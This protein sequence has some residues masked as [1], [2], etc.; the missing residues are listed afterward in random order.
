MENLNLANP[1]MMDIAVPANVK[2]LTFRSNLEVV[3]KIIIIIYLIWLVII[4]NV[5]AKIVLMT[6]VLA[7]LK[8]LRLQTRVKMLL[9]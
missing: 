6:N 9:L 2:G 3:F 4:K 8:R 1:K 5:H 7:E